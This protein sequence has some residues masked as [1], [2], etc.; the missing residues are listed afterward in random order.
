MPK[1]FFEEKATLLEGF[2]KALNRN[3]LPEATELLRQSIEAK[4]SALKE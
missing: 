1:E 3:D 4:P 2:L